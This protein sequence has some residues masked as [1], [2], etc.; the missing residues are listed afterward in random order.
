MSCIK[1][2]YPL[3]LSGRVGVT[4]DV[5]G[6]L[7]ATDTLGPDGKASGPRQQP[8]QTGVS[9]SI[10]ESGEGAYGAFV[11]VRVEPSE[12]LALVPANDEADAENTC[13]LVDGTFRCMATEAGHARFFAVSEG[14]WSG[15]AKIV[16]SWADTGEQ[17]QTIR[18]N[19]PG[20]PQKATNFDLIVG[21][22]T[23]KVLATNLALTCTTGPVQQGP[24]DKWR[25][26]QIRALE[27][28][29]RATPPTVDPIVVENAPVIIE[30]LSSEGTLS[31]TIDCA[32]RV[33]RLRVTL[34]ASGESERFYL[35]FS[36]IGGDVEYA[37]SSGEYAGDL[38]PANRTI[39]VDPE[40]R[41]LR[42]STLAT[43]VTVGEVASLFEV[44]AY[45]AALDRIE[46][47][48]DLAIDTS[49]LQLDQASATLN[50]DGSGPTVIDAEA[51]IEG[52]TRL[53]VTPRLLD[54]P[55]C[56]SA[57]VTVLP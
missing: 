3:P 51:K 32:E 33:T 22:S 19:P 41:L 34:A 23:D 28:Y 21:T 45:D 25:A 15:D 26:G 12:A 38:A 48:V 7:F 2:G 57:D 10:T 56:T 36:D 17:L 43:T 11:Y 14:D 52:T 8:S 29:A 18:V 5:A 54:S 9:L 1:K 53:H 47:D 27:A 31:R 37:F 46:M 39:S 42:V 6:P 24:G 16:V 20:L 49:I 50:Q 55:D 30:S 44:S 40:P 4:P 35:C 13:E